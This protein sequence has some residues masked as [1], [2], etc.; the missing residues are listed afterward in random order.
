M[1]RGVDLSLGVPPTDLQAHNSECHSRQETPLIHNKWPVPAQAQ[2]AP[3]S[4]LHKAQST[5]KRVPGAPHA[6][7]WR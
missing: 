4:W 1:A 5:R 3:R 7:S 6:A 2:Y